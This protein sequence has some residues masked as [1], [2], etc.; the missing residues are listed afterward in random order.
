[1]EQEYID[2]DQK[3]YQDIGNTIQSLKEEYKDNQK[4]EIRFGD[5]NPSQKEG[6]KCIFPIDNYNETIYSHIRD[7]A[8]YY[9]ANNKENEEKKF[10][11]LSFFIGNQLVATHEFYY[12]QSM[13]DELK[14]PKK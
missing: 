4:V 13:I 7:M 6:F 3:Q 5:K 2:I 14:G 10:V 12:N 1:M 9:H 11:F 8:A